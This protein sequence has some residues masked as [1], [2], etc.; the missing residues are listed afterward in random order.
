M[1]KQEIKDKLLEAVKNDSHLPDIKSVALFGS[2]IHGVSDED[3]DVNVLM[4]FMPEANVVFF[5]LAQIQ[6]SLADLIGR[7]ADLLTLDALSKYFRDN[8]L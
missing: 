2:H 3:S 4:E 5:K 1:T 7:K 8:V 6:R